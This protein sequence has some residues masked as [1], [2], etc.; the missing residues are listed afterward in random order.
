MFDGVV[1]AYS[2]LDLECFVCLSHLDHASQRQDVDSDIA[3]NACYPGF[4]DSLTSIAIII[5]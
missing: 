1:S 2:S 3:S 5:S 4:F